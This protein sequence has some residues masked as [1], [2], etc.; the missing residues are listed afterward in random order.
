MRQ[1]E[2]YYLS[3]ISYSF[4]LCGLVTQVTAAQFC[5]LRFRLPGVSPSLS[6]KN[7]S[8]MIYFRL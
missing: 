1:G 4:N 8:S 5:S 2:G 3:T 7:L 6:E